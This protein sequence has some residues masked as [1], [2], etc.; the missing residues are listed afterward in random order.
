MSKTHIIIGTSAAGIGVL[1]KLRSLD[2]EGTIIC[3]S[4]EKE[5]PYNKCLLADYMSGVKPEQAV[6][7]RQPDFFKNN[8]IELLLGKKVVGINPNQQT[9]ALD[10]GRT[11]AYDTLFLGL[12]SAVSKPP[13]TCTFASSTFVLND[14]HYTLHDKGIF[15]FHTLGNVNDIVQ[16]IKT[17]NVRN[18]CI[19]G[20]GLSGLECADALSAHGLNIAVVEKGPHVLMRQVDAQGSALIEKYMHNKGITL[21]KNTSVTHILGNESV[22]KIELESGEK[23][24]ADLLIIATGLKPR[25]S[26]ATESG[27][28]THQGYIITN[29]FLQTNVPTIWAGG[30]CIMVKDQ[31]TGTL[32]PSC[33]WPDAMLQ[34]SIAAHGMAGQ[35]K[36]YPGAAII[37]STAF[38][39]I[40]FVTCGLINE[41]NGECVIRIGQDFYHKLLIQDGYLKGY[42]LVGQVNEAPRLKKILL[43]RQKINRDE[44]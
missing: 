43:T 34:G 30:D 4:D 9:V 22:K 17:K 40:Q 24:D 41:N 2:P 14:P 21:L 7:T 12:G 42:L 13:I 5:L 10:D 27:I 26:L 19:L 28:E 3:I 31:L 36:I 35:K 18:V 32:M 1:N 29:D 8:S 44:I 37:S 33:A 23:I 39:G 15:I 16:Y 11:L 25:S 38:F 6:F 20:A